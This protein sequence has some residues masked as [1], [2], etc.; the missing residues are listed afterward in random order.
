MR[1]RVLGVNE[2]ERGG[3]GGGAW[4]W[5]NNEPFLWVSVLTHCTQQAYF[6]DMS[7]CTLDMVAQHGKTTVYR[8]LHIGTLPHKRVTV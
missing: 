6:I 1:I 8:S 5:Q 2:R 3:G 7:T 4:K